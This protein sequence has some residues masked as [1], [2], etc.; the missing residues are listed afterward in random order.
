MLDFITFQLLQIQGGS[1]TGSEHSSGPPC[2]QDG[3][4][5]AETVQWE[6][7]WWTRNHHEN[8]GWVRR[9]ALKAFIKYTFCINLSNFQNHF[10][11][12]PTK[13]FILLIF[14]HQTVHQLLKFSQTICIQ[15]LSFL[16]LKLC[17]DWSPSWLWH[18]KL[19]AHVCLS[20][21]NKMLDCL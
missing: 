1:W 10:Q 5:W 15:T 8:T 18:R 4:D 21:K 16:A 6:Q 7:Q 20:T 12:T 19:Q 2:F 13:L 14:K 11:S 17:L 9:A 3:R